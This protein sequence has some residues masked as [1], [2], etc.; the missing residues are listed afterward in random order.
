MIGSGLFCA[1]CGPRRKFSNLIADGRHL[2]PWVAKKG[3]NEAQSA[4][5]S[6]RMA[7]QG[8]G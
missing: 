6:L 7:I 4:A 8:N 1:D 3:V 5:V 2:L